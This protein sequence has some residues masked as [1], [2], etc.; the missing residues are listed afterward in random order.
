MSFY[1]DRGDIHHS[2]NKDEDIRDY[3]ESLGK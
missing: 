2:Y 1:P 3:L